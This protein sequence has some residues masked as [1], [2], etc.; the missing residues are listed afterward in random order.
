MLVH[1][2]NFG[3]ARKNVSVRVYVLNLGV[4]WKNVGIQDRT[5]NL[6]FHGVHT[7]NNDVHGV[8]SVGRALRSF[9]GA[10]AMLVYVVV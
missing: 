9:V 6:A 8:H 2:L 3:V 1:A 5:I 7:H 10:C 4:A